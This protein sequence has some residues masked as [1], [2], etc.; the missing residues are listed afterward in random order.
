[1]KIPLQIV[2]NITLDVDTGSFTVD[3]IGP[4]VPA[5]SKAA[6][7]AEVYKDAANHGTREAPPTKLA[8]EEIKDEA[9]RA[10]FV[11]AVNDKGKTAAI[12]QLATTGYAKVVDIPQSERAAFIASLAALE[13]ITPS[14]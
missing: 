3:H 8:G 7:A 14:A 11:K 2:L 9:I 5:V 12:A 4:P 10:A 1:M 6:A 13:D